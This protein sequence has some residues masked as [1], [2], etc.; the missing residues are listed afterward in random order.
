MHPRYSP[1]PSCAGNDSGAHPEPPLA[2]LQVL[3]AAAISS[4]WVA[5]LTYYI[6]NVAQE[7]ANA[8]ANAKPEARTRRAL[9]VQARAAVARRAPPPSPARAPPL[10][11]LSAPRRA[12]ENEQRRALAG[13]C[14]TCQCSRQSSA[15]ACSSDPAGNLTRPTEPPGPA[16]PQAGLTFETSDIVTDENAKQTW[17]EG[18]RRVNVKTETSRAC[19]PRTACS[20]DPAGSLGAAHCGI[21]INSHHS[22]RSVPDCP[23]KAQG[24]RLTAFGPEHEPSGWCGTRRRAP[25]AKRQRLAH[26]RA[27]PAPTWP[28]PLSQAAIG[29]ALV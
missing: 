14:C 5:S 12:H 7:A 13:D 9:A 24:R 17:V 22:P 1:I 6:G 25:R 10:W 20:A 8:T 29:P 2:V 19:A 16:S 26:A 15:S 18:E 21:P 28:R 27:P 4:G 23:E 11:S 3:E